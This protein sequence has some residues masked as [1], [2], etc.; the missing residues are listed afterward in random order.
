MGQRLPYRATEAGRPE[1]ERTRKKL[2]VAMKGQERHKST[3]VIL[4]FVMLAKAGI[5][6]FCIWIPACAGMTDK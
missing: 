6:K 1:K 3:E 5:Q 4:L 2:T